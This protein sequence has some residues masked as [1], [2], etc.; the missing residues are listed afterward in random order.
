MKEEHNFD[1]SAEQGVSVSEINTEE[2]LFD[3]ATPD[4]SRNSAMHFNILI[5]PTSN[6]SIE[7]DSIIDIDNMVQSLDE[8]MSQS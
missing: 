8:E 4:A 7:N 3:Y 6:V 5:A 2:T 1:K